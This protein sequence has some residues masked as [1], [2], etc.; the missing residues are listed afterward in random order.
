M[1]PMTDSRA[2]Q[3]GVELPPVIPLPAASVAEALTVVAGRPAAIEA[4]PDG[5]PVQAHRDGAR[6]AVFGDPPTPDAVVTALHSI[7]ATSVIVDAV[8]G[9]AGVLFVDLLF[10]DGESWVQRPA[11]ERLARLGEIA[12]V[13]T[14]LERTAADIPAWAG[15]FADHVRQRGAGGVTVR[16]L[17]APRICGGP[18]EA[19]QVVTFAD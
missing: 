9:S 7:E 11:S 19:V 8:V 13:S 6:V 15:A 3:L 17:D 2:A 12:P 10:L 4:I 1:T 16:L 18:A 14:M 5:V